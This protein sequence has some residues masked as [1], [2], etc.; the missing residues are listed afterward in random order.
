M[1]ANIKYEVVRD[2]GTHLS[3]GRKSAFIQT[4][5]K[6]FGTLPVTIGWDDMPKLHGMKAATEDNDF[7]GAFNELLEAFGD[8]PERKIRIW[9]EY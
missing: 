9:A 6:A 4:I 2:G 3:V 5:E 8:D 1:S 7:E